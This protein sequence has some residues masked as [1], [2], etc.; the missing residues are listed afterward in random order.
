[1]SSFCHSCGVSVTNTGIKHVCIKSPMEK[2]KGC[3]Q[4]TC[5]CRSCNYCGIK[6][7]GYHD[8][9]KR[10]F[11]CGTTYYGFHSCSRCFKCG[12]SYSGFHSCN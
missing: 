9:S 1:M 7:V 2:C 8:C 5:I 11:Q 3:N 6:Y 4:T 10:C 12:R